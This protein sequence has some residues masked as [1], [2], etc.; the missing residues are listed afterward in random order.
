MT[1]IHARVY[2]QL[3]QQG[4]LV[5][6]VGMVDPDLGRADRLAR[7]FGCRAFASI[8]QLITTHSEAGRLGRGANLPASA[9]PLAL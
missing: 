9:K 7:E 2:H 4:E 5:R 1:Q 8:E 3:A 6:L